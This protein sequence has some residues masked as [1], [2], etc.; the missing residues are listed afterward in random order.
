[1]QVSPIIQLVADLALLKIEVISYRTD[2]SD[3][4]KVLDY[5]VGTKYHSV[6]WD[7][8]GYTDYAE[9]LEDLV[10]KIHVQSN[11]SPT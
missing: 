10:D 9:G 3:N 6:L 5:K 2:E 1:M 7:S 11:Q 8:E 4:R